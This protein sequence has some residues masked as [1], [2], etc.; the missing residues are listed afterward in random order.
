MIGEPCNGVEI[1]SARRREPDYANELSLMSLDYA[2]FLDKFKQAFDGRPYFKGIDHAMKDFIQ[3]FLTGLVQQRFIS[4]ESIRNLS[5]QIHWTSMGM[6]LIRYQAESTP[7]D[8]SWSMEELLLF[9]RLYTIYP[10]QLK[11]KIPKKK[12]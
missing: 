2:I 1:F 11:L 10:F 9:C 6:Y 12:K 5:I 8:T 7:A 4:P 3:T